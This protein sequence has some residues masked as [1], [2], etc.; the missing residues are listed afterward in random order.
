M[1]S[2]EC[3]GRRVDGSKSRQPLANRDVQ[4][5]VS[6]QKDLEDVFPPDWTAETGGEMRLI[7]HRFGPLGETS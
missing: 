2:Y 7:V 4:F 1:V 6:V 3:Y 5:I